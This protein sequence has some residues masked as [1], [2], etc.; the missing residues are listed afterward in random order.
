MTEETKSVEQLLAES[1]DSYM[2]WY[3]GI[4]AMPLKSK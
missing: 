3:D 1:G 4:I 2:Q